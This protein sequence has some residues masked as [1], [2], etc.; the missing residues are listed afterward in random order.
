MFC[1]DGFAVSA[2]DLPQSRV[3]RVELFIQRTGSV[4][5]AAFV[6]SAKQGEYR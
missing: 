5:D 4:C 1:A 3:D 2:V 6:S